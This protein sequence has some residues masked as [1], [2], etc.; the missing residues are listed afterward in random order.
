MRFLTRSLSDNSFKHEDVHSIVEPL[1]ARTKLK[2]R[3]HV[4]SYI[5]QALSRRIFAAP[6]LC[7]AKLTKSRLCPFC[8][9][10][11]T[12][13]H[14][15]AKC[16][17]Y[18]ETIALNVP[19]SPVRER[20]APSNIV[21]VDGSCFFFPTKELRTATA[22][23]LVPGQTERVI[24]LDCSDVNSLRAEIVALLLVL[25]H[26]C[27]IVEMASECL[28]VVRGMAAIINE[29][30]RAN[31]L[32]QCDN[33][34]LWSCVCDAWQEFPGEINVFKVKAHAKDGDQTQS[35]HLTSGNAAVDARARSA[36]KRLADGHSQRLL[37]TEVLT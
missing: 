25:R 32:N 8:G 10:V 9:Q 30:Q 22:A 18:R 24:N 29:D 7:A 19:T 21:F 11:E 31:F 2:P 37:R 28:E 1:L 15:F 6:R 26:F 14:L 16:D 13:H 33:H 3:E 34:D 17:H 23:Y 4:K 5:Q 36:A 35:H 20:I 12:H 27:G